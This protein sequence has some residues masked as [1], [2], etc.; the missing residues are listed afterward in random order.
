L[1]SFEWKTSTKYFFCE[2]IW[3]KLFKWNWN[4]IV[5]SFNIWPRISSLLTIVGVF[6]KYIFYKHCITYFYKCTFKIIQYHL[7]ICFLR[8]LYLLGFE[9][10]LWIKLMKTCY[11]IG[12]VEVQIHIVFKFLIF[13][14]SF[15]HCIV[16]SPK[17]VPHVHT[18]VI[19][20]HA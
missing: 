17:N 6:F 13:I 19:S 4:G 16:L 10:L 14:T 20:H 18:L 2:I 15:V 12:L 9:T 1:H 3:L 5:S 8:Q 11:N 7:K